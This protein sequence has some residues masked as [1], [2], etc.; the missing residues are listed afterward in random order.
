MNIIGWILIVGSLLG[1]V[2]VIALSLS[3]ARHTHRLHKMRQESDR[4]RDDYFVLSDRLDPPKSKGLQ[5]RRARF[6]P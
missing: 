1:I 6:L 5:P 4:K 2:V 3:D